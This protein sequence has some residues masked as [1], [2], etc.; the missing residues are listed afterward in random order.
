[1]NLKKL[2]IGLGL[3][4]VLCIEGL[5]FTIIIFKVPI[6]I[7]A[8]ELAKALLQVIVIVFIGQL[9]SLSVTAYIQQ[10]EK[11]DAENKYRSD[12]LDRL[13][14]IYAQV[15]ITRWKLRE[16]CS[17]LITDEASIEHATIDVRIVDTQMQIINDEVRRQINAMTEE[18]STFRH[19]FARWQELKSSGQKILE[20][21]DAMLQEYR[22]ITMQQT[23]TQERIELRNFPRLSEFLLP[24]EYSADRKEIITA[25]EAIKHVILKQIL[26]SNV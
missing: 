5:I 25:Y 9:L 24:R 10:R 17:V 11:D 22:S 14:R 8:E 15:N 4:L 6:S 26:R 19:V 13:I 7:I 1:M 12:F 21:F 16:S 23:P 2:S 18:A 3:V 20:Y